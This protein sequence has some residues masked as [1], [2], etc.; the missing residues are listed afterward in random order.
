MAVPYPPRIDSDPRTR[1]T[2]TAYPVYYGGMSAESGAAGYGRRM[3]ATPRS[4]YQVTIDC[5]DT[6][7][8]T[9]TI[10]PFV[11]SNKYVVVE[12][13]GG[14]PVA[15]VAVADPADIDGT[16]STLVTGLDLSSTMAAEVPYDGGITIDVEPKDQIIQ[17]T[18]TTPGTGYATL[19]LETITVQTGWK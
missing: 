7:P 15:N 8:Q 18:V 17:V 19:M 6:E 10:P 4:D 2:T 12:G 14:A 5:A 1:K 13:G 11:Y 3:A 9:F 16:A